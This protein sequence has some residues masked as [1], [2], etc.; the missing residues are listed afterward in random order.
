MIDPLFPDHAALMAAEN[1]LTERLDAVRRASAS[2]KLA[3]GGVP[4]AAWL[5]ELRDTRFE[6]YKT[7]SRKS[8]LKWPQIPRKCPEITPKWPFV[9]PSQPVPVEVRNFGSDK[10]FSMLLPAS[11]A[12]I[13]IGVGQ[14]LSTVI[15]HP[16]TYYQ[17]Q[18]C[19]L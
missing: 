18:Q 9:P 2:R 15:D 19:G 4:S 17:T 3:V 14:V 6:H 11:R 1:D 5:R 13:M 16:I 7:G 12:V 10:C 8:R